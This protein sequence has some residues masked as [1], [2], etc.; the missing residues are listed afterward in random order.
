MLKEG[1][2]LNPGESVNI[3]YIL[4][5]YTKA[6]PLEIYLTNPKPINIGKYL[7]MLEESK[8]GLLPK[9]LFGNVLR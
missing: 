8:I 6:M 3:I 4:D 9:K 1:F 5:K 2:N 7:K